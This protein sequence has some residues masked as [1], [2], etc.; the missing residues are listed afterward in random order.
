MKSLSLIKNY[1]PLEIK[2]IVLNSNC[3]LLTQTLDSIC[4]RCTGQLLSLRPVILHSLQKR[5][6]LCWHRG[7]HNASDFRK[8][9]RRT[10]SF[11]T[12]TGETKTLHYTHES[13]VGCES[14]DCS[15]DRVTN[16]NVIFEAI[17]R[18]LSQ[19]RWRNLLF[20]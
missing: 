13:F 20:Y 3:F 10:L 2:R 15:P 11:S 1:I 7:A 8:L 19:L 5:C 18:K 14:D 17:M 16:A 6:I 9:H 4:S 12:L